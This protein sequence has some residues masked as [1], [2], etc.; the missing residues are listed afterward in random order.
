[1]AEFRHMIAN[2]LRDGEPRWMRSFQAYKKV[3][4]GMVAEGDIERLAPPRGKARNMIRLTEEG[5]RWLK[6]QSNGEAEKQ[7]FSS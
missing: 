1:M 6:E 5:R 7:N 3:I 4:D 2:K